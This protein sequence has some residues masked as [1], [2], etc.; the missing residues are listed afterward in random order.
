V[1]ETAGTHLDLIDVEF[2][3]EIIAVYVITDP[4]V[5]DRFP[6]SLLGPFKQWKK[7]SYI[8]DFHY[9]THIRRPEMKVVIFPPT[10]TEEEI[11]REVRAILYRE[12]QPIEGAGEVLPSTVI[13]R[14]QNREGGASKVISVHEVDPLVR[15]DQEPM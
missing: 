1:P 11:E 13:G 8:S 3:L 7:E 12:I 15:G 6:H 5:A 4:T 2:T 10:A 14:L 9:W